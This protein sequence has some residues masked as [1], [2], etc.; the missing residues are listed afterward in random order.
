MRRFVAVLAS[1]VMLISACQD[2]GPAAADEL[3]RDSAKRILEE[4]FSRSSPPESSLCIE[5]NIRFRFEVTEEQLSRLGQE[6]VEGGLVSEWRM[7][8]FGP[9]GRRSPPTE[10]Y[11]MLTDD[12]E[13]LMSAAPPL[14]GLDPTI[15]ELHLCSRVEVVEVTGILSAPSDF[16]PFASVEY[17]W[18]PVYNE[19]L[20]A[21]FEPVL[22]N[23]LRANYGIECSDSASFAEFDD[24]WRLQELTLFCGG[25]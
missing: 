10:I 11:V 7:A 25:A 4:D 13:R 16:G 2:G 21:M 20:I 6:L 5:R 1:A 9:V 8:F 18:R 24:G 15:F 17:T 14:G 22:D 12:G 19:E 3:S 23:D